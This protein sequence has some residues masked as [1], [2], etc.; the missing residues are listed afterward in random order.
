MSGLFRLI[1]FGFIF[2]T[3]VYIALSLYSRSVRRKKLS[4]EWEDE[5]MEG[6]KNDWVR[7]GLAEYDQS[8]RRKLILGV[9]VVP[10]VVIGTIIYLVNYT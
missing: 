5:G 2:L 9:Y 6:D 4:Q 10:L 1:G 7:A 3:V 8:L